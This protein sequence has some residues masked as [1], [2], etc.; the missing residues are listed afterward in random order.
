M[1]DRP[2]ILI[3]G[4]HGFLGK[5]VMREFEECFS[6]K[7]IVTLGIDRDNDI[8]CDL[9]ADTPVLPEDIE[10]MVDCVGDCFGPEPRRLNVDATSRLL[11]ALRDCRLKS[12][13]YFSSTAVFGNLEGENHNE[14]TPKAPVDAV[15]RSKIEAEELLTSRCRELGASLTVFYCPSIIGTGMRGYPRR[16]VNA[17]YR[18]F[19]THID[20]N[21]ARTS[22]IHAS[23]VA[24]AARLAAIV[25]PSP[26]KSFREFIITDGD[27]PL[28]HDLAEALAYRLDDKRIFTISLAKARR[29]ARLLD[30]FTFSH[31]RRD[32]LKEELSTLTFSCDRLRAALGFEPTPVTTYLRTHDYDENSL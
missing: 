1:N 26:D 30:L 9:T 19:Y 28:R 32:D 17:I 18:G 15:G 24:K 16:L 29:M 21:E 25:Q 13:I 22:V 31:K 10:I 3:A 20:G 8:V 23:D 12:F 14:L 6:R 5:Y 11:D 27:N 4:A 2:K 7:A